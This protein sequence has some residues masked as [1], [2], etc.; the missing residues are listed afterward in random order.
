KD[1]EGTAEVKEIDTS[2]ASFTPLSEVIVRVAMDS[3]S[4]V[5]KDKVLLRIET[6]ATDGRYLRGIGIPT[7]I[8]GPGELFAAHSYNEYVKLNDIKVSLDATE[9]IIKNYF[10]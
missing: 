4:R 9:E 1:L 3:I 7:I 6:G 5:I 2:E 8:Y 10:K